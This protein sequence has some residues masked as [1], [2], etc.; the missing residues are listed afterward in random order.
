MIQH[1]IGILVIATAVSAQ[2]LLVDPNVRLN[3]KYNFVSLKK[4]LKLNICSHVQLVNVYQYIY[5]SMVQL[6]LTVLV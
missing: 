3:N 6:T 1:F 4:F 2:K 5:V